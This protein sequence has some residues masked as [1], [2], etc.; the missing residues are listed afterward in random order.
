MS[1]DTEA[2]AL[3][4]KIR[5][6]SS[7]PDHDVPTLLDLCSQFARVAT[8]PLERV[9]VQQFERARQDWIEQRARLKAEFDAEV[10]HCADDANGIREWL[11]E[12]WARSDEW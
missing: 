12:L 10:L 6:L 5:Q 4:A 7:H 11:E 3:L 9:L 1:A 2:R 8:T